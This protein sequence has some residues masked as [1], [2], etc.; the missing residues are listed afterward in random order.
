MGDMIALDKYIDHARKFKNLSE[1]TIAGYRRGMHVT[2]ITEIDPQ[3]IQATWQS[4]LKDL[5]AGKD[6]G[7][8]NFAVWLII[9]TLKLHGITIVKDYY[10]NT[11]LAMLRKKGTVP[12]G[13]TT[14]EVLKILKIAG[15]SGDVELYKLLTILAYSGIRVSSAEGIR[16]SDMKPIKE[17]KVYGFLCRAKGKLSWAFIPE[18]A[19][20][21]LSFFTPHVGPIVEHG[22]EKR[23]PF[24]NL[25]RARMAYL[26]A[27]NKAEL[28]ETFKDKQPF[29]GLRKHYAKC[30]AE[31]N[32]YSDDIS[33]LMQHS[34]PTIAY[35]KYITNG[36]EMPEELLSRLANAYSR[37]KLAKMGEN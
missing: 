18:Q 10:L 37:T 14:E 32:L 20:R 22:A 9:A 12:Q 29:H 30:L 11:I 34:P 36:K 7:G 35:R 28:L 27:S 1:H 8:I 21:N 4:I 16:L 2:G 25:Y 24:E 26:I 5:E 23:T 3:N 13:F 31:A 15:N 33:M 17:V 19:Y 6:Y